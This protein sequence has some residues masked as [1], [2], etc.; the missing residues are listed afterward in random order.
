MKEVSK[1]VK[2]CFRLLSNAWVNLLLCCCVAEHQLHTILSDRMYP[3]PTVLTA[4]LKTAMEH[5]NVPTMMR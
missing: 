1:S 4:E 2:T 3:M 5:E